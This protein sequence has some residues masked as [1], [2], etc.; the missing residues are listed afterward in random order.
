MMF[1]QSAEIVSPDSL[2][3]KVRDITEKLLQRNFSISY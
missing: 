1:G 3:E 2:R